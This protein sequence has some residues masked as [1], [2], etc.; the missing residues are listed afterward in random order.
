[1]VVIVLDFFGGWTIQR[2]A[3]S[4][5]L[6]SLSST[7]LNQ[8]RPKTEHD[9]DHEDEDEGEATEHENDDDNERR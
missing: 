3:F 2:E 5:H 1:V 8:Q 6:S 4:V 9:N 7:A